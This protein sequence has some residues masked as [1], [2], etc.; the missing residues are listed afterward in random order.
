MCKNRDKAEVRYSWPSKVRAKWLTKS[1]SCIS[2]NTS[3]EQL[4]MKLNYAK[5]KRMARYVRYDLYV[6][7]L[8]E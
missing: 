8:R 2:F 4:R 7:A 1:S 6:Y 3:V 5:A